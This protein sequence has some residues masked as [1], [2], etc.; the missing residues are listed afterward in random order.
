MNDCGK[1]H[2]PGARPGDAAPLV[3]AALCAVSFA[4]ARV[5][6]YRLIEPDAIGALCED[7]GPAW[8]PLR[9]GLVIFTEW[10]GFAWL[11]LAA[12]VLAFGAVTARRIRLARVAGFVALGAGG[13]GM[14]LYNATLAVPAALLA[15][16]CLAWRR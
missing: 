6:R 11:A 3:G 7:G 5:L 4:A 12:A 10:H 8:C 2:G 13:F 14:V 9:T 16:I 1:R 15:V